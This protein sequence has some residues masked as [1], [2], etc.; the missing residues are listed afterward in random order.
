MLA[1][2]TSRRV[3][4]KNGRMTKVIKTSDCEHKVFLDIEK[5]DNWLMSLREAIRQGEVVSL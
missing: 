4:M 2:M 3:V 1:L 5:V